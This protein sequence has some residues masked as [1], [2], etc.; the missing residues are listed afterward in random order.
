MPGTNLN[1]TTS[2]ADWFAARASL[3][4]RRL[5]AFVPTGLAV[6]VLVFVT[7]FGVRRLLPTRAVSASRPPDGRLVTPRDTLLLVAGVRSATAELAARDSALQALLFRAEALAAAPVLT[8]ESQRSRDSLRAVLVQ[9]DGALSRATKAPLVASYRALAGTRAL[10]SVNGVQELVDSLDQ[11]DRLRLTLD[12]VET[13]QREFARITQQSN[14]LGG[15]LQEL[16]LARRAAVV[17]QIS[18]LEG[19]ATT[20]IGTSGGSAAFGG[21]LIAGRLARDSARTRVANAEALLREARRE[22]AAM[23]AHADSAESARL[24]QAFGASPIVAAVAALVVAGVLIFT[25][26][27]AAEARHPSVAH[28]REVERIFGVP[29]L[30]TVRPEHLPSEGRARLRFGA[31]IDPLRMVYLGLTASG[32]RERTVCITGDD[33]DMVAAVAGRLAVGAAADAR[34][35]LV[36]DIAPG[37]PSVTRYF[38]ARHEP[39]FSEAISAVRLWREVARPVGTSEGLGLDVVPAG[40]RRSDTAESVAMASNRSE[41]LLFTSEYDFTVISAPTRES[42]ATAVRLCE[43]PATIYVARIAKTSLSAMAADVRWLRGISI[44]LRGILLVDRRE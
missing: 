38:G 23:R 22:Y 2:R 1:S 30:G 27:V 25:L 28:A 17:R 44:D 15:K 12:P 13:S 24:T 32:T 33:S 4:S 16:G 19:N 8:P 10:R 34:A 14:A 31:G 5:R 11:F 36:V 3:A 18:T 40:A 21:P 41:F 43:K 37:T 26:A 35:T 20:G 42:L 9:L 6:F 29:V 7:V 39:G